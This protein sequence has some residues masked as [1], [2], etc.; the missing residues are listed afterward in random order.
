MLLTIQHEWDAD[1]FFSYNCY[2]QWLLVTV[3][4]MK[5]GLAKKARQT[6]SPVIAKRLPS[7]RPA[8]KPLDGAQT[9]TI[10]MSQL[11]TQATN[12]RSDPSQ[13]Y[14]LRR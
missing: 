1:A 7:V 6:D 10:T 9:I 8:A 3:N 14:Q 11:R 5:E 13:A 12:S 4:V 2:K